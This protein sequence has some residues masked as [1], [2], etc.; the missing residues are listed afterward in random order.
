MANLGTLA[1]KAKRVFFGALGR[2]APAIEPVYCHVCGAHLIKTYKG[3]WFDPMTGRA[4]EYE[5]VLRCPN[6]EG[7]HE[8]FLSHYCAEWNEAAEMAEKEQEGRRV[9]HD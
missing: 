5:V 1:E 6:Y 2:K 8:G 4:L 3:T 9:G 7:E